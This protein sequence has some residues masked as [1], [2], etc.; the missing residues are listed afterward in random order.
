MDSFLETPS[1]TD[2]LIR[3]VAGVLD[4]L[5]WDMLGEVVRAENR[6]GEASSLYFWEG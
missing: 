5:L 4:K 1:L 3:G 2:F 6:T